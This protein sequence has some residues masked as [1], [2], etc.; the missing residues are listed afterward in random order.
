MCGVWR[1]V[2][3]AWCVVCGMWC[4]VWCVMCDV[5][6]VVCGVWWRTVYVAGSEHGEQEAVMCSPPSRRQS[7]ACV[8][9]MLLS[10]LLD[11]SSSRLNLAVLGPLVLTA[12]VLGSEY[13]STARWC[14]GTLPSTAP[15]CA[16]IL[17][18]PLGSLG[19]VCACC[20]RLAALSSGRGILCWEGDVL[21]RG[22][23]CSCAASPRGALGDASPWAGWAASS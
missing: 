23:L 22:I 18:D 7:P 15:W 5:W 19:A 9:C 12:C 1:V 3:G 8:P 17:V 16:C 10:S 2:C 4:D 13:P 21:A 14:A 11:V 20:T 6:C